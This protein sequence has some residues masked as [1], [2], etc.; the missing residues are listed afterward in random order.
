MKI[1]IFLTLKKYYYL[2]E[3][4]SRE[5]IDSKQAVF[6]NE[7]IKEHFHNSGYFFITQK[8]R[9]LYITWIFLE[10]SSVTLD[11]ILHTRI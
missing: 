3:R 5:K 9:N 11:Q 7:N 2:K 4:K 1:E 6:Q 8:G 10:F